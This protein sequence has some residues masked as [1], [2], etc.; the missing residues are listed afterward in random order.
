M[1]LTGY[2]LKP[3]VK[4][5]LSGNIGLY[6]GF[7]VALFMAPETKNMSLAQSSSIKKGSHLQDGSFIEKKTIN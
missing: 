4:E 2:E 7:L 1:K 6:I 3:K 5:F